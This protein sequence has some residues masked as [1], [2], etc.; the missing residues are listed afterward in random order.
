MNRT[1]LK[2]RTSIYQKTPIR[3]RKVN[4]PNIQGGDTCHIYT[5]KILIKYIY[6]RPF[7]NQEKPNRLEKMY[8][9]IYILVSI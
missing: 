1:T 9:K 8:H 6:I 3:E 4:L 5:S 7:S 2:L